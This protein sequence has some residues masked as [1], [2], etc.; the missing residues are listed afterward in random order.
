MVFMLEKEREK[1]RE[2][3]TDNTLHSFPMRDDNASY[4]TMIYWADTAASW[5]STHLPF[6]AIPP[7]TGINIPLGFLSL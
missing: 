4:T 1:E 2:V 5:T 6:L 3:D 7:T